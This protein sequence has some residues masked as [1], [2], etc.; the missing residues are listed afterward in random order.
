M[1]KKHEEFNTVYVLL[2]I[3]SFDKKCTYLLVLPKYLSTE[4]PTY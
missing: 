2:V 4:V 3:F 1:F